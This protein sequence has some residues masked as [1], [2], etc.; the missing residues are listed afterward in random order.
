MVPSLVRQM[1][2]TTCMPPNNALMWL[3]SSPILQQKMH[4]LSLIDNQSSIKAT[5]IKQI[6]VKVYV[7]N[8]NITLGIGSSN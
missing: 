6:R 4:L 8:F 1:L 3:D 5:M 7:C 2:Y